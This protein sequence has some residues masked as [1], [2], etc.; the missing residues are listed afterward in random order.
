MINSYYSQ[1][2]FKPIP[3]YPYE[4][5]ILGQIRRTGSKKLLKPGLA[6]RGRYF[7]VSLCKSGIKKTFYVHQLVN[8]VWGSPCPPGYVVDH[9]DE[10][11]R[12]NHADNLQ[13]ISYQQNTLKY[14]DW[15]SRQSQQQLDRAY[16]LTFKELPCLQN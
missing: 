12:N 9:I 11:Q 13:V 6:C 7:T 2:W 16:V 14:F 10:D 4:V 3:H 8:L 5:N 1:N 15:K